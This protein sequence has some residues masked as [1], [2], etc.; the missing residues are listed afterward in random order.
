MKI[1]EGKEYV[2]I[3]WDPDAPQSSWVHWIVL[4]K[5]NK[6][7]LEKTDILEYQGP[8]PPSGTHHYFFSLYLKP[9]QLS[10]QAIPQERGYFN[11]NQ[12]ESI[13]QL[14]KINEVYMLVSKIN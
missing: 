2:L 1:E 14:Q 4:Y 7:K 9:N 10:L 8:N 6:N 13:N 11:I 3:M 5:K 12:F